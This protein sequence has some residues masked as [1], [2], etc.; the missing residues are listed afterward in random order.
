MHKEET[1]DVKWRTRGQIEKNRGFLELL[2]PLLDL[3]V[4]QKEKQKVVV[5]M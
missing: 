3:K 1:K 5:V 4:T 2:L